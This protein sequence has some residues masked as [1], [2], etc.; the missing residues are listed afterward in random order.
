M[1]KPLILVTN[2]DGYFAK[3][4]LSLVE[5]VKQFGDVIVVAPDGGRSGMSSA[6]TPHVPIRVRELRKEDHVTW[7]KC[8]G[9]PVDCVKLA[10]CHILPRKPDLVVSGINHG[11]N[12][13]INVVYS[14]T[15][16]ATIEGCVQGVPSI[17]FSLCSH[18]EDADFT[19]TMR[20]VSPII[21]SVLKNGLPSGVCLNVN[22]PAV[23]EVLGVKVCRQAN[24]KWT[25]DFER[26]NDPFGKNIYWLTGEFVNLEPDST[27]TDIW[28]IN[29]GFAAVVP[30]AIDHTAY[31]HLITTKEMFKESG[32][33]KHETE[34]SDVLIASQI[35]CNR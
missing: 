31:P 34:D 17:G 8:S 23:K 27:D 2:D 4:I 11:S 24:S 21:E 12:A 35:T 16:G 6:L 14:G 3:G 10:F 9:T 1:D 13:A 30:C 15:M 19:E 26:A 20:I 7:Y 22:V 33:L 18:G 28:A 32:L 5:V 25:G 29:H